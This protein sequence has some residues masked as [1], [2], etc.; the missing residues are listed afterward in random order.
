MLP[1]I[2]NFILKATG[3]QIEGELPNGTS[4][5]S[6]LQHHIRSQGWQTLLVDYIMQ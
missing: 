3:G 1:I 5:G 6:R 2:L 4:D